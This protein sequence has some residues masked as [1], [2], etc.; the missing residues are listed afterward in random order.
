MSKYND[1]E[2][3]TEALQ[4]AGRA[5]LVLLSLPMQVSVSNANIA[6]IIFTGS[7][8]SMAGS[9]LRLPLLIMFAATHIHTMTQAAT[10]DAASWS[11]K[12]RLNTCTISSLHAQA[13]DQHVLL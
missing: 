1:Q 7:C 5:Y 13:N 10:P 8:S 3:V 2:F 9:S 12:S 6:D 4:V 11:G